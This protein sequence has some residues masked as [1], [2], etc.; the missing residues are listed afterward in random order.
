[1][2]T[3]RGSRV[4][5]RQFNSNTPFIVIPGVSF[6]CIGRHVFSGFYFTTKRGFGR[7]IVDGLSVLLGHG[8]LRPGI[9]VV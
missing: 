1:M 8:G 7:S 6:S 4:G 3:R 2:H 5:I 9:S